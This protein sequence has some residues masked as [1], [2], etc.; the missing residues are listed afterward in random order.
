MS[1][2]AEGGIRTLGTDVSPYNGLANES[3]LAAL[4]RIQSPTVVPKLISR[5]S[6]ALVWHY[7]SPFCAP[8]GPQFFRG[9]RRNYS[10]DLTDQR[11]WT[12]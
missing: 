3:F 5:T 4:T 6:E 10:S 11:H 12:T 9:Q 7:C 2:L 1:E 8:L